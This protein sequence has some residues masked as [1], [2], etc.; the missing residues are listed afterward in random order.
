MFNKKP[1][2][3]HRQKLQ[4]ILIQVQKQLNLTVIQSGFDY[5]VLMQIF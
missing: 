4:S 5:Q 2:V 3:D 1:S